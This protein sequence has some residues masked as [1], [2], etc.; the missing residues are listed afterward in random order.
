MSL[1]TLAQIAGTDLGSVLINLVIVGLIF[2][3]IWWALGALGIPEPINKVIRV[4]L[5]LF[6]VI[7]LISLLAGFGG[8]PIFGRR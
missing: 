8:H 7:W 3:V 2:W 4:I 1:I 6:L 5:I